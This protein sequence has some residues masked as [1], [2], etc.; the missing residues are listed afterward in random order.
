MDGWTDGR[1]VGRTYGWTDLR[2]DLWTDGPTDRRTDLRTDGRTHPP[3]G[4]LGASKK[5]NNKLNRAEKTCN[6]IFHLTFNCWIS[7]SIYLNQFYISSTLKTAINFFS[8]RGTILGTPNVRSMPQHH[9]FVILA[10]RRR[11]FAC[12]F[13]C[14]FVSFSLFHII[15]GPLP[16]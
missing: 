11:H 1:T 4:M 14:V 6:V 15:R 2:T 8:P 13:D 16:C 12:V 5:N 9:Y 7:Q 10:A 3:I